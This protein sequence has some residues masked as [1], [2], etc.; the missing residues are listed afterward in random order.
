[1]GV[2]MRGPGEKQLEVDRRLAVKRIHELKEELKKVEQRRQRE[3]AARRDRMTVSLRRLHQRRQ[4]YAHECVDRCQCRSGRQTLRNLGYRTRRWQLPGCGPVL[5][6]DTVG[7]IRDLPHHLI[8][9]FRATL[10]EAREADLLMHVADAS[11]PA[12]LQQISSVYS[13]LKGTRHRRKRYV[14]SVR[15]RSIGPA[16]MNAVYQF[17]QRYPNAIRI[18]A[19]SREGYPELADKVSQALS[20]EFAPYPSATTA[21]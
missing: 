3:V 8:A 15:T 4:K 7:F 18:S 21:G 13:V 6:S 11:N 10:E 19:H 5:L 17:Q 2:G 1:M 9:S 20:R 12:V 16:G 14:A